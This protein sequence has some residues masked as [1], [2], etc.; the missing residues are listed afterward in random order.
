MRV[1]YFDELKKTKKPIYIKCLYANGLINLTNKQLNE[2]FRL[3]G[4][5]ERNN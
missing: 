4:K 1:K 3:G 2:L 5:N